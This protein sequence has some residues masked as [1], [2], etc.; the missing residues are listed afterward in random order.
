MELEL[1]LK[2]SLVNGSSVVS[3]APLVGGS[4]SGGVVLGFFS[5]SRRVFKYLHTHRS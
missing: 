3:S 1:T 2:F 5:Q 4:A